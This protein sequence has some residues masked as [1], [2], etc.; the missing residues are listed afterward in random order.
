MEPEP[1]NNKSAVER[2]AVAVRK[3]EQ[4]GIKGKIFVRFDDPSSAIARVEFHWNPSTKQW[5]WQWD[6][7][8]D[9]GRRSTRPDTWVRVFLRQNPGTVFKGLFVNNHQVFLRSYRAVPNEAARTI[10]AAARAYRAR[11]R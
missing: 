5:S 9:L 11:R 7:R 2:L 1:R 6:S 3:M 4:L 10:Q 8:H